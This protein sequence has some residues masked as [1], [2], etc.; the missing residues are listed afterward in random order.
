MSQCVTS[1]G[2]K[3]EKSTEPENNP[4]RKGRVLRRIILSVGVL[5]CLIAAALYLFDVTPKSETV[6][7]ELGESLSHKPLEYLDGMKWSVKLSKMDFS[8]VKE[9]RVGDYPLYISH[10][11][12]NYEITISV[13]DTTAP[14]VTLKGLRYVAEVDAVSFAKDYV[15]TCIDVDSDVTFSFLNTESDS[16]IQKKS[17]EAVVFED[18]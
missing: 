9:D 12:D 7:L 6:D 5:C 15:A 10:G 14:R 16:T 2:K 8:N 4:K 13:K 17:E 11:F 3:D 1:A 18:E